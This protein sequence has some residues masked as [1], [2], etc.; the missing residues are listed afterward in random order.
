MKNISD[1][2]KELSKEKGVSLAWIADKI[3]MTK[4]GFYKAMENNSWKVDTIKKICIALDISIADFFERLEDINDTV[5]L[6]YQLSNKME[7]KTNDYKS[8][9]EMV[10]LA[11]T[12]TTILALKHKL[13]K[14]DIL[15]MLTDM[16]E[17]IDLG[18]YGFSP[19]NPPKT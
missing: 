16:I 6:G 10:V 11:S 3:E 4:P 18:K 7:V 14:E 9:V 12:I 13:S 8:I 15:K 19:N 2:I 5:Q 1:V 17:K